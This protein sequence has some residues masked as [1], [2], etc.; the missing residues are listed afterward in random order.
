MGKVSNKNTNEYPVPEGSYLYLARKIADGVFA[1]RKLPFE[2]AIQ[3]IIES[4][5][6]QA[7]P[8]SQYATQAAFAAHAADT[9]NPHGVTAAQVGA[10]P[11]G[12]AAGQVAAHE[13]AADPHPQYAVT[14]AAHNNGVAPVTAPV[15]NFTDA[16]ALGDGAVAGATYAFAFLG[17]VTG[18]DG[19]AIGRL[20]SAS[21]ALGVAIGLNANSSVDGVAVGNYAIAT[22]VAGSAAFGPRARA[23]GQRSAAFGV[24]ADAGGTISSAF[25]YVA[26]ASGNNSLAL[27]G[28]TSATGAFS[29]ACGSG[30]VSSGAASFAISQCTV[31][32]SQSSAVSPDTTSWHDR[33]T[34]LRANYV[35]SDSNERSIIAADSVGSPAATTRNND[36][37]LTAN[38]NFFVEA[39]ATVVNA[40]TGE[41]QVKK[42]T[43]FITTDATT[44]TIHGAVDEVSKETASLGLTSFALTIPSGR[45]LRVSAVHATDNLKLRTFF[46]IVRTTS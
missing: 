32:H 7:N 17:N 18:A 34:I 22:G 20:S 4:H 12:T 11:T 33:Q 37:T 24:D 31:T 10:D 28:Q 16:L 42:F 26:N 14:W 43:C 45:T 25:G 38:G 44:A 6:D 9:G 39:V 2:A 21:G 5:T 29:V 3:Q 15:A 13:A 30:S 23:D 46:D 1:S 27:G 8:H 41:K 40:T 19:I 36:I 35:L